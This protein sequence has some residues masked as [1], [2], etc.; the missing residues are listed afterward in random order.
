MRERLSK[1]QAEAEINL[2]E[3]QRAQKTWYDQQAR[4]ETLDQ[5]RR[6]CYSS[7]LQP[8][9]YCPSGKG[10]TITQKMGPVTY[11]IHHPDKRKQYQTYHVNLLKEWKEPHQ[12]PP[13]PVGLV[14]KGG[15]TEKDPS[16]HNF[17]K[18]TTPELSHLTKTQ[19][20][21]IQQGLQ[22]VPSLF[23]GNPGRT[24]LTKH[25]IRLKDN[26]PIR[27]RPYRVPQQFVG[28][29]SEEISNMQELG[30]IEPSDSEWC[31]TMILLPKKD[32]SL[33][34]CIDFRR[35]N[36]V[37]EFD[38]YPMP[39]VDK[40]LERIGLAGYITTLCKRYWQ[41]PLEPASRPTQLFA[42]L[43]VCSSLLSCYLAA[44]EHQH[45]SKG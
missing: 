37:S 45:P 14:V 18:M 26:R 11:E 39:R 16:W 44:M 5:V 3:A 28:R 7:L 22:T 29:L 2:K 34:H 6:F 35:L 1:Y 25:V 33:R 43:Q 12:S 4:P 41:V 24:N 32:G 31:S 42:R 9:S 19:E 23:R 10:L 36:A 13:E 40:L 15:E 27:Q 30:V 20:T 8:A 38:A 21:Q 17:T